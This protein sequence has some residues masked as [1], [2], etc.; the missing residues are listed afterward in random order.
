MDQNMMSGS[1]KAIWAMPRPHW[2]NVSV[3]MGYSEYLASGMYCTRPLYV[4]RVLGP[5]KPG[6]FNLVEALG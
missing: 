6:A 2:I 4:S 3:D 5:I 1:M